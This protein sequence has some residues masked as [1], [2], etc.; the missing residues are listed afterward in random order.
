ML[1]ANVVSEYGGFWEYV[2]LLAMLAMLVGHYGEM[3]IVRQEP[4]EDDTHDY[5]EVVEES[6]DDDFYSLDNFYAVGGVV[7]EETSGSE[8]DSGSEDVV[9]RAA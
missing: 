6:S 7:G 8:S 4:A 2:L 9:A 5:V 3:Y 1:W